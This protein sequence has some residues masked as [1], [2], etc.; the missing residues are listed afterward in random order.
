[1]SPRKDMVA[2]QRIYDLY[3]LQN[4]ILRTDP[5][6]L[7]S[8][9]ARKELEKKVRTLVRLAGQ[10]QKEGNRYLGGVDPIEASMELK[11]RFV[12]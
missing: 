7:R 9:K 4:E 2:L 8:P 11:R 6:S 5:K 3:D 12:R 1:M 10:V